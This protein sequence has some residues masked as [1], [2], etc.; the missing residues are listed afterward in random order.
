MSVDHGVASIVRRSTVAARARPSVVVVQ[1]PARLPHMSASV[2]RLGGRQAGRR[3]GK[4]RGGIGRALPILPGGAATDSFFTARSSNTASTRQRCPRPTH[5]KED[6]P[7]FLRRCKAKARDA[8]RRGG[9]AF[10]A[11]VRATNRSFRGAADGISAGAA[12]PF[13][14]APLLW[15]AGRAGKPGPPSSPAILD[16]GKSCA[17]RHLILRTDW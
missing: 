6:R 12:P 11:P 16:A 8:A 14:V 17:E 5:Q 1:S 9:S 7:S 3:Q 15:L 2:T 10:L 4:A 13:R